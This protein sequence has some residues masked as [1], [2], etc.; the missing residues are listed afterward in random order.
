M[1]GGGGP[2]FLYFLFNRNQI[3]HK[4]TSDCLASKENKHFWPDMI[5]FAELSTFLEPE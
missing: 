5:I 3:V 2:P 1:G 4:D